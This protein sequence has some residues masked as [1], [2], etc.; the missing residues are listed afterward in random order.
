MRRGESDLNDKWCDLECIAIK[1]K[2]CNPNAELLAVGPQPQMVV[3]ARYSFGYVTPFP[4][5]RCSRY[6]D[7]ASPWSADL[8][9]V[10]PVLLF[11]FLGTSIL[12][13]YPPPSQDVYQFLDRT[14]EKNCTLDHL[15]ANTEAHSVVILPLGRSEHDLVH[16]SPKCRPHHSMAGSY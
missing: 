14:S 1:A 16:L 3:F 2:V 12:F 10:I 7:A 8:P 15:H 6:G 11:Q 5:R 4:G 13:C 9:L